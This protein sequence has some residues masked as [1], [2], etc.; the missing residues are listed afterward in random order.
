MIK[1]KNTIFHIAIGLVMGHEMTHGFDD[2]WVDNMIKTET[3]FHGGQM[4][5]CKLSMNEKHALLNNT[6]IIQ[7]LK[8]MKRSLSSVL[9][10][11][12]CMLLF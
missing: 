8:S 10:T 7:Y 12:T 2:N 5:L 1:S 4:K 3:K 6:V 9:L 11:C